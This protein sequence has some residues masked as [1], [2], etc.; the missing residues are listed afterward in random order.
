MDAI[1]PTVYDEIIGAAIDSGAG[2]A[3]NYPAQIVI[4][5]SKPEPLVPLPTSG[6]QS[7][8][9]GLPI[10]QSETAVDLSPARWSWRG[11]FC[12]CST[13]L[14][15]AHTTAHHDPIASHDFGCW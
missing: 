7:I 13:A 9:L 11:F 5:M 14:A 3:Y 15:C 4:P 8:S 12:A 1:M 10:R 6:S 2:T